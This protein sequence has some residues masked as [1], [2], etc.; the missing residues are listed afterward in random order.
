MTG[1]PKIMLY[2]LIIYNLFSFSS[3]LLAISQENNTRCYFD[4]EIYFNESMLK[5]TLYT[6]HLYPLLLIRIW[7]MQINLEKTDFRLLNLMLLILLE[8]PSAFSPDEITSYF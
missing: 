7:E 6:Q 2:F 8:W 1:T 3:S 4:I 5:N